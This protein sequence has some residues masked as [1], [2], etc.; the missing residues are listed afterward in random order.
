M[1][2]GAVRGAGRVTVTLRAAASEMLQLDLDVVPGRTIT[3]QVTFSPAFVVSPPDACG[4]VNV[5]DLVNT[6]ASQYT[7]GYANAALS[8]ITQALAC[9]EDVRM[10]RVAA[11][12]ACASH[13]LTAAK[14]YFAKVPAQYQPP[15][16][17][18]CQMEGLALQPDAAA[19]GQ[20]R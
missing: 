18:K 1:I 20:K 10:Y 7:A 6:A 13:D 5:D 11:M 3:K 16:E 15:I 14:L 19:R 4:N 2:N 12:Y 9:K 17:Q 8:L